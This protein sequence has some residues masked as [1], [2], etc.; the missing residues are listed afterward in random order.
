MVLSSSSMMVALFLLWVRLT[1][2]IPSMVVEAFDS[3]TVSSY[4]NFFGS[5]PDWAQRRPVFLSSCSRLPLFF[6]GSLFSLS[7][8]S[9]STNE[10]AFTTPSTD[11]SSSSSFL[12]TPLPLHTFAGQVEQALKVN[13]GAEH[14]DRVLHCWRRLEANVEYQQPVV[15]HDE[16]DDND[17]DKKDRLEPTTSRVDEDDPIPVTRTTEDLRVQQCHSHVPGLTVQEF[18]KDATS[19]ETTKDLAWTDELQT[20]FGAAICQEFTNVLQ[21]N[22]QT[23]SEQGN[24]VWSAALTEEAAANYGRGWKTLVLM[25]R[26]VWDETN[27][28]FFP[29]TARAIHEAGVPAVE[30]F[31]ARMD[32]WATIPTHSDQTNFVLTSHLGIQIPSTTT[33]TTTTPSNDD[34]D[35]DDNN[36]DTTRRRYCELRVGNQVEAWQA[37]H[38][39]VFDTSLQHN[40]VNWTPEPRT[41]LMMRVWHPELTTIEKQ[42]LQFIWDCLDVPELATTSVHG[43]ADQKQALLQQ[44]QDRR[45]FPQG[46][47]DTFTTTMDSKSSSMGFGGTKNRRTTQKKKGR[48]KK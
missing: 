27:V 8:S 5:S 36:K 11:D 19:T 33:T 16:D 21:Q 39:M 9:S 25:D 42:A 23:L 29:Q 4:K 47:L 35:D 38:V 1:I 40:A 14:V 30:V 41:I 37:G 20:K 32:P 45:A 28:Q 34:N 44:V 31:F 10:A 7:S 22:A 24:N 46:V 15:L 13:F 43:P 12:S 3:M 18:W 26:G 17:D 48:K 2:L 6:R